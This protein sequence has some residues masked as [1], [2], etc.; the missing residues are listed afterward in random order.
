MI[1]TPV[2]KYVAMAAASAHNV[3]QPNLL[4]TSSICRARLHESVH[5]L[6]SCICSGVWAM[7][8]WCLILLR[9]DNLQTCLRCISHGIVISLECRVLCL[10]NGLCCHLHNIIVLCSRHQNC[11]S[12]HYITVFL[13]SSASLVCK[14]DVINYKIVNLESCN[15]SKSALTLVLSAC[16]LNFGYYTT[17]YPFFG[18]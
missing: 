18:Q 12:G 15:C 3:N 5:L 7:V 10:F 4:V 9:S 16:L 6:S 14:S 1:Q 17:L 8:N 13:L 11:L 2:L